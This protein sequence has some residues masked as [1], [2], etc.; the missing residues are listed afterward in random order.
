MR[1]AT[2]VQQQFETALE[3][4]VERLQQD[5]QIIAA[6]LFGSLSYDSVWEKSDIDLMLISRQDQGKA[7]ERF[8]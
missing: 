4:L 3:S 5:R 8:F 2:Q 7:P 1:S 6:I